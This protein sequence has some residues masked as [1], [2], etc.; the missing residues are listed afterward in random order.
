MKHVFLIATGDED[1]FLAENYSGEE[2]IILVVAPKHGLAGE[3]ESRL[4]KMRGKAEELSLKLA[5]RG[6][7]NRVLL[8]WGD[9]REALENCLNRE[10]AIPLE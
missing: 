9:P 8:E 2:L 5:P 1:T 3:L 6:V 7:P 10:G 4:E